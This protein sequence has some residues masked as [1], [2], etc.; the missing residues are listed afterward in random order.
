[1][2]PR[3]SNAYWPGQ[4]NLRGYD[5]SL[6]EEYL[7]RQDSA[8]QQQLGQ[9]S[10]RGRIAAQGIQGSGEALTSAL[11]GAA[12]GYLRGT[13]AREEGEAHEQR[14]KLS[15][16][17]LARE[18][19]QDPAKLANLQANTAK[20]E[21]ETSQLRD[22]GKNPGFEM[23]KMT[24]GGHPIVMNKRTGRPEVLSDINLDDEEKGS[25]SYTGVNNP[26]GFPIYADKKG[27]EKL[28][29]Y[30]ATPKG[31]GKELP[32]QSELDKAFAKDLNDWENRGKGEYTGNMTKLAEAETALQN[33][34]T[35]KKDPR[36][37]MGGAYGVMPDFAKNT[38]S[39][40]LRDKVHGAVQG[41]LKATLGS[42]FTE[43]EG[44]RIM[45]RAYDESQPPDINLARVQK[46][47]A[48][49]K[50]DASSLER[51]GGHFRQHGTLTG[52]S[53]T[54]LADIPT[55]G[56]PPPP[57]EQAAD[58]AYGAPAGPAPARGPATGNPGQVTSSK[59]EISRKYS[60]SRKTTR[61][62]FSDG[63]SQDV[64]DAQ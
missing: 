4:I 57:G 35:S 33:M 42:Q 59:K 8:N 25:F 30:A 23:S 39:R 22:F 45:A 20:T 6:A 56:G 16:E 61:I 50:S 24:S 3:G 51:Q 54:A 14:M 28:G 32:G 47:I 60:P 44:E 1:V 26:E 34:V 13:K 48:K 55:G 41:A 12:N 19:A 36:G 31:G 64:P 21:E 17:E 27:N 9:M 15:E 58:T 18:K 10:D 63:T 5:P 46:E 29:K 40:D 37:V 53:P 43:K 38:S 49:L 11:Q 62:L 52:Y 7:A 2:P